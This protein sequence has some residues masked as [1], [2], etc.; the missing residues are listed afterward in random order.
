MSKLDA[1]NFKYLDFYHDNVFEFI[2]TQIYNCYNKM[3]NDYSLIENNENLIRNGLYK[4]YLENNEIR[5]ELQLTPYLFD[6]EVELYNDD[7]LVKGR[8]DIKVYNAIERT[9][10]TDAYYIIECKRIDGSNGLNDKY[11]SNGINRFIENEKYPSFKKVNGMIGFVVNPIDIE[12]NTKNFSDLKFHQ[13]INNFNYSYI[14]N[15]TTTNSNN[16]TL[17]HLMLDYSSKINTSSN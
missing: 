3:L 4:N 7:D 6:T 8:T 10:N 11:I 12:Q 5:E 14:S 1:S 16:I 15:H 17:Y 9:K 2:L 13:F